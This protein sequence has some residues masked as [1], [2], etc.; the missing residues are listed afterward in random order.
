MLKKPSL[1]SFMVAWGGFD[2]MLPTARSAATGR[3]ETVTRGQEPFFL[4]DF[5]VE[6]EPYLV[7]PREN[8]GIC[9]SELPSFETLWAATWRQEEG[10]GRLVTSPEAEVISV[11]PIAAKLLAGETPLAIDT[12]RLVGKGRRNKAFLEE[13]MIEAAKNASRI[14]ALF[15]PADEEAPTTFVQLKR[16]PRSNYVAVQMKDL[17]SKVQQFPDLIRLFGLTKTEYQAVCLLLNG[18]CVNDIANRLHNSVLTVRTHL[19]RA[20]SKLGISSKE[21]LFSMVLS[22]LVA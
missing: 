6:S 7:K 13:L 17:R 4:A 2:M 15:T 19:K 22:L 14:D 11:C 10:V 5:Q 21:Q 1:S 18:L 9:G 3:R 16:C 8:A 12:G 20:Y